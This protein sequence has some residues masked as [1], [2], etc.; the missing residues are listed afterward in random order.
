MQQISDVPLMCLRHPISRL[1]LLLR[2][3][4]I[5]RRQ[6]ISKCPGKLSISTAVDVCHHGFSTNMSEH[7]NHFLFWSCFGQ[8]WSIYEVSQKFQLDS[9]QKRK[10]NCGSA[11]ISKPSISDNAIQCSVRLS[12]TPCNSTV[13]LCRVAAWDLCFFCTQHC[14]THSVKSDRGPQPQ[15]HHPRQE[16]TMN[17]SGERDAPVFNLVL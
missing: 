3:P 2:G 17:H 6:G 10:R 4:R 14:F 1:P 8:H 9:Q 5:F 11:G 15:I 13:V 7:Q 16:L 12:N